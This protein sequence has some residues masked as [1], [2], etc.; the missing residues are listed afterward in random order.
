MP[1]HMVQDPRI[2]GGTMAHFEIKKHRREMRGK[3]D[4]LGGAT[5]SSRWGEGD[6]R[7]T[8]ILST[9]CP[10]RSLIPKP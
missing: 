3:K 7:P 5:S 8:S 2:L 4:L 6:F 1:R 9:L 10:M